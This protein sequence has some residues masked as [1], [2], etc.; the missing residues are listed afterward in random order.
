M[1]THIGIDKESTVDNIFGILILPVMSNRYLIYDW[2][3]NLLH[4][5]REQGRIGQPLK[6]PLKGEVVSSKI[7]TF[8]TD[9]KWVIIPSFPNAVP[10][11]LK[12]R[13]FF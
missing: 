7:E 3:E 12:K 10:K 1:S 8:W 5:I 11:E 13:S 4:L 2:L 9:N 6:R